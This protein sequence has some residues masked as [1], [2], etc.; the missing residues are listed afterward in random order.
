MR[1]FSKGKGKSSKDLWSA[2]KSVET[3]TSIE[4]ATKIMERLGKSID[5]E[6]L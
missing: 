6:M 4:S 1:A 3:V 2:G 5:G